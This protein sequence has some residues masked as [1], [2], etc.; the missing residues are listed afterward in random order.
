MKRVCIFFLKFGFVASRFPNAEVR[1][2]ADEERIPARQHI[3]TLI[4]VAC[5]S[6]NLVEV[7]VAKNR[8]A[9][10]PECDKPDRYLP[11]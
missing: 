1:H 7:E 9:Y 5:H 11:Q 2:V 8:K 10:E 3:N 4:N 6:L